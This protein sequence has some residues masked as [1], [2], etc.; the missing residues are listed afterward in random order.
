[1]VEMK[2]VYITVILCGALAFFFLMTFDAANSIN[3]YRNLLIKNQKYNFI[4][5]IL[6]LSVVLGV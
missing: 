6:F 4:E 5:I 1:M 3:T 2:N